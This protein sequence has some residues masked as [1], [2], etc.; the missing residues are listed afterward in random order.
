MGKRL[1]GIGVG[2]AALAVSAGG[3]ESE[4]SKRDGATPSSGTES[5]IPNQQTNPLYADP[6]YK[7][8]LEK[9]ALLSRQ[10]PAGV[11]SCPMPVQRPDTLRLERLPVARPSPHVSLA[12]Q[13]MELRCPNPL[14]PPR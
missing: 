6:L 14:D 13:R 8:L 11:K 5:P 1:F 2:L 12:I 4:E 9:A 7:A 10:P 3:Q